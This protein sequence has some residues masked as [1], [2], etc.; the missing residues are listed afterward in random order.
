MQFRSKSNIILKKEGNKEQMMGKIAI[1]VIFV[2]VG[3]LTIC[4]T[5]ALAE[6]STDFG[7]YLP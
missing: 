3:I 6:E 5:P 2:A 4:M 1:F 7:G